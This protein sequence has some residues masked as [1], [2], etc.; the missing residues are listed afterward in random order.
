MLE[1]LVV[2]IHILACLSLVLVILL[3]SGKGG[4]V[5]A[6]FGGGAGAALGT[7][8]ASTA[9][10][11]FTAFTAGTFLVTSMVLAIYSSPTASD[12]EKAAAAENKKL[13]DQDAK[14]AEE[15][16]KAEA[17]KKADEAKKADPAKPGADS[18]KPAGGDSQN[19]GKAT[20]E[21]TKAA[22]DG[23]PIEPKPALPKAAEEPE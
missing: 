20:D 2:V 22:G 6:A 15:A 5:S 14:K 4:G 11:K 8:S 19:N 10:S 1:N 13:D 9:L 18:L 21:A 17:V 23:K 12:E 3:Q 16:K 7:R